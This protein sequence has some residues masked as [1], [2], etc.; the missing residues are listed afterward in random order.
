MLRPIDKTWVKSVA[1]VRREDAHKGTFGRL[2]VLAGSGAY[3]GAAVLAVSGALRA[4]VGVVRLASTEKVCAAVMAQLPCCTCM[5]LG[6][7]AGGGVDA[8]GLSPHLWEKSTSV[9]AGPGLGNTEDT[10]KLILGLLQEC[11]CPMVLDAD[12]LNVMAGELGSGADSA[13]RAR[14][15]QALENAKPAV[16]TPH[17]GEMARLC[18]VTVEKVQK[19]AGQIA[20][21]FAQKYQCVVVL[22]SHNTLVASPWGSGF[23]LGGN[24]NPG[25]AKGGS[26]DV[27]AGII[28]SLLAQG[29][30]PEA[31][32]A[33]GVWLHAQAGRLAAERYSEA[34]LSPAD[35]PLC[36]CDI[37]KELENH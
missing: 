13:L 6:E 21:E 24:G 37:W 33:A 25:L 16:L 7:N 18:G 5:P 27:L 23:I 31:A 15:L 11:P 28:A 34:G 9:L 22:K 32:A 4:G 1:P 30:L 19:D 36:L 8:G 35:L 10:A 26:G 3:R 14:M 17:F 20:R 2:A 12:A 29:L